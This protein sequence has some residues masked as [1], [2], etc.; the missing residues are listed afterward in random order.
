MNS[1]FRSIKTIYSPA[2]PKLIIYMLQSVE[3]QVWPYLKW[4]WRTQDFSTVR[5]RKELDKT[6]AAKLLLDTL[7]IGIMVEILI[8]L[9]LIVLNLTN[10]LAGGLLFGLALILIAPIIWAHLI[11]IPLVAGRLLISGPR[12]RKL[13]RRSKQIFVGHQGLKI[14]VAGSYGKTSMKELLRIVLSE[15]KNVA[16][17]PANKNVASSHAVF[18]KKL[19]G[20]EDILI[21]EFGEGEP[22]DVERF[23]ST[24]KPDVALITG[25]SP[26]HLDKYKTIE[27]A[28]KDIFSL[29]GSLPV[30]KIYVNSESKAADAFIKPG[31]QTY[32]RHGAL[33]WKVEA[34]TSNLEGLSFKLVKNDK[35]INIKSTLLGRHEI[36]PISIV[37]AIAMEL[38]LNEKQ[39]KDG[40]LKAK[41]YE[42]RMQPYV[43]NHAHIIDDTYNGN[44]EG[45]RAGTELLYELKANN[46]I[47]VS[48]GLVDQGK[49]DEAV[50]RLMGE[51]IADAKPD[52]VVLMKNSATKYIEAGLKK[53][54]YSG[55]LIIETNPLDFY[56]NLKNFVA[57]GDIVL[58]Q[59]DWTDN[60][61]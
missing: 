9:L 19:T 44:I 16:A 20:K 59:N 17:T 1:L 50:H 47:Y 33:G 22:G 46:K 23:T 40:I 12:E 32:N 18:A 29:Y 10:H 31:Y 37:A 43:L 2:F 5:Q 30:E 21:I 48:P 54:N 61:A 35:K 14:A 26:A 53:K 24:I 49:E 36:G 60:Y 38:G 8:G 51:L 41:A 27:A 56:T 39:V 11:C 52:K 45:I 13:I 15:G 34:V 55:Q 7:N 6:R 42:H 28:G 4:F 58:M 57:S 25:L 3:Y